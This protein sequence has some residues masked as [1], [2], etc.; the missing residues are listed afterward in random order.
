MEQL[1]NFKS[2]HLHEKLRLN[3]NDF[4]AWLKELG[5]LHEKRTCNKCGGRTTIKHKKCLRFGTWRCSMMNCRAERGYLTGTFFQGTHLTTKQIFHLSF[6]WTRQFGN[7]ADLEFEIGIGR[8]ALQKWLNS[9]KNVCA[10]FCAR[11]HIGGRGNLLLWSRRSSMKTYTTKI[12]N[13]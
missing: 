6:L 7:Y 10:M 4:D 3:D 11:N 8:N 12:Y 5:L 1:K 13:F 2:S 9:F